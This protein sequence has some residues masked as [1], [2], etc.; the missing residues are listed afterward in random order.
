MGRLPDIIQLNESG[1][2]AALDR[3]TISG[4]TIKC[5]NCDSIFDY[6]QEGGTISPNPWAMPVCGK[7]LEE[8]YNEKGI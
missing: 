5:Y 3:L 8:A 2:E 4:T 6:D 7:C 1:A